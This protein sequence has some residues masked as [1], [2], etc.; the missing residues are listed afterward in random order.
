MI[1]DAQLY[2]LAIFLGSAAMLLIVLYH[3]LEVNAQD[4]SKL[5][6]E[7]RDEKAGVGAVK[8]PTV[9]EETR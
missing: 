1:T 5:N 7:L 3:F 2:S 6:G 8:P 4:D 9:G